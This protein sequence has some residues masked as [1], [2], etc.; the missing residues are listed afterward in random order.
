[1]TTSTEKDLS[2]TLFMC[3]RLTILLFGYLWVVD[4]GCQ[5]LQKGIKEVEKKLI[6]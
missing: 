5:R 2:S 1:M 3:F 4:L 6:N